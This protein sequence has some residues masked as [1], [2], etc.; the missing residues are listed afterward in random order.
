MKQVN[1]IESLSPKEQRKIYR[2]FFFSLFFIVM[3]VL[4]LLG[5]S[6]PSVMML[7]DSKQ[8]VA[9]LGDKV[10]TYAAMLQEKA[11]CDQEKTLLHAKQE[12]IQKYCCNGY[13][14]Y[15]HL[16]A[17]IDSCGADSVLEIAS[18]K[19]NECEISIHCA[20]SEAI[21]AY[22]QRLQ[23]STYFSSIKVLS[24]QYDMQKK[25]FKGTL[26]GKLNRHA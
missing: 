7:M 23:E 1:C 4:A 5:I 20:Q 22:A 14:G 24:I 10:T 21:T 19:K 17:L 18:I 15:D 26:K 12:Y 9:R 2:W 3:T 13:I 6:I 11:Q 16:R 8:Q 25:E